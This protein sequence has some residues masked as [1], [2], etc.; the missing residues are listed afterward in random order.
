MTDGTLQNPGDAPPGWRQQ[1]L[2]DNGDGTASPYTY[3]RYLDTVGCTVRA[4]MAANATQWYGWIDISAQGATKG[5]FHTFFR[6]MVDHAS[7]ARASIQAYVITSINATS[8]S[9]TPLP[10]VESSFTGGDPTLLDQIMP[11]GANILRTDVV[12]GNT[13]YIQ[14]MTANKLTGVTAINTATPLTLGFTFTPAVGDIVIQ[15]ASTQAASFTFDFTTYYGV[16]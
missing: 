6:M 7:A 16:Y 13:P 12:S 1:K 14:A 15:A 11:L 2:R 4:T 9:L 3:P 8:A 10:G 5:T